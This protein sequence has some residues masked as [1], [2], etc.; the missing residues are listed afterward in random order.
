MEHQRLFQCVLNYYTSTKY[1]LGTITSF[2]IKNRKDTNIQHTDW[3]LSIFVKVTSVVMSWIIKTR[4]NQTIR[5][6]IWNGVPNFTIIDMGRLYKELPK[7]IGK[8]LR[9][10]IYLAIS[11]PYTI[12]RRKQQKWQVIIMSAYAN[13]AVVSMCQRIDTDGLTYKVNPKRQNAWLV[14]SYINHAF[15]YGR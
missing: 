12:V 8:R 9:S 6:T 5:L 1:I 11:L 15:F 7:V 13:G 2:F 14:Y 3:L 10:T 4:T